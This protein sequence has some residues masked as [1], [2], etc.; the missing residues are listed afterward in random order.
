MQRLVVALI[1]GARE[2]IVITTPYF[3]PD[4]ALL[5]A[6]HTAVLRGVEVHLVVS[7]KSDQVLV[8]LAQRSYYGELLRAGV[9]IHLYRRKFLHAKHLSIDGAV[10]MI[11]SSNIDI[12]SF[13]LNAEISLLLY[14]AE[15]ANR[16]RAEQDRY[17]GHSDELTEAGW[18]QRP[19]WV[20]VPQNLAR[21]L[22]PLL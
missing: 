5:Q 7:R 13:V 19:L 4:E 17:I 18:A 9:K 21:L 16:L 15:A 1:H 12:R 20:K 11:G 14:S 8:G 22:S 3:I 2:R 10:A 6:L